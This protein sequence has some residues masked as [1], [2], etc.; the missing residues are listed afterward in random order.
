[1][2]NGP[3]LFQA[4]RGRG[5]SMTRGRDLFHTI[6]ESPDK[7]AAVK[8]LRLTQWQDLFG[9]LSLNYTAGT[10]SGDVLGLVLVNGAQRLHA[11]ELT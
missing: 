8:A 9:W 5:D 7:S 3:A 11:A 1:M 2:S 10:P 6:L 4:L